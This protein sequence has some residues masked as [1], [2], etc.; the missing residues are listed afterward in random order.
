MR[1]R[2]NFSASSV[3]G[4]AGLHRRVDFGRGDTQAGGCDL[5]PVELAR[6]LDQSGVA[7]GRD[8]VDDGA[9]RPLDIG[10]DFALGGEKRRKPRVEIGAVSVEANGHGG[11]LTGFC[12]P[13]QWRGGWGASTLHVVPAKTRRV[14]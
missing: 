8:V 5:E 7:A 6:R 10:G 3:S 1:S 4:V 14:G 9:G 13:A 2:A 11:F 12:V